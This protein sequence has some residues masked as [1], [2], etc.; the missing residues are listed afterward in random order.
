MARPSEQQRSC[1]ATRTAEE[2][3]PSLFRDQS[4]AMT[5]APAS[6]S[7]TCHT[8]VSRRHNL[9]DALNQGRLPRSSDR[10][11]QTRSSLRNQDTGEP[12]PA[13]HLAVALLA[14]DLLV[15]PSR[16][17]LTGVKEVTVGRGEPG[18]RRRVG[19]ALVLTLPDAW[20]S[21]RHARLR[22]SPVVK[23]T[24]REAFTRAPSAGILMGRRRRQGNRLDGPAGRFHRHP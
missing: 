10:M 21:E 22:P 9:A 5:T 3:R 16:H 18:S 11:P 24:P 1:R 23:P 2:R 4:P 8:V 17:R 15:G 14:D 19:N 20:L 12:S 6:A 13:P 7:G